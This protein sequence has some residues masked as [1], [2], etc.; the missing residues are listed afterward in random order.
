LIAVAGIE[1]WSSLPSSASITTEPLN[2]VISKLIQNNLFM[3]IN[4]LFV[5]VM[6]EKLTYENIILANENLIKKYFSKLK[7]KSLKKKTKK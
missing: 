2:L 4:N 1:M 6:Y 7:N 3:E 5:T